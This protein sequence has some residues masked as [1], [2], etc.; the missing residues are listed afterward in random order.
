M[1]KTSLR[2]RRTM[3]LFVEEYDPTIEDNFRKQ[4]TVDEEVAL[5]SILDMPGPEEFSAGSTA[6]QEGGE[7]DCE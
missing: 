5:L 1:G 4:V 2:V 3:G 7:N 6:R